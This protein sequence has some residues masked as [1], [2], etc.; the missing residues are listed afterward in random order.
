VD[1]DTGFGF[2]IIPHKKASGIGR[3]YLYKFCWAYT[4]AEAVASEAHIGLAATVK[5]VLQHG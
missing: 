3:L 1:A 4:S 5:R 2:G